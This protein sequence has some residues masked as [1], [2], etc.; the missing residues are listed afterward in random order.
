LTDKNK[1]APV[2]TSVDQLY[3]LFWLLRNLCYSS[4]A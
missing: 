1:S 4:M 2:L 3:R